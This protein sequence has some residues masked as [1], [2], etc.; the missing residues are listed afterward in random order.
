MQIMAV[1]YVLDLFMILFTMVRKVIRCYFHKCSSYFRFMMEKLRIKC[2]Q[3]YFLTTTLANNREIIIFFGISS[4]II[5]LEFL[6]FFKD[7]LMPL[8]LQT[9]LVNFRKF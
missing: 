3:I 9:E 7:S 4:I 8:L 1:S 5:L 6:L 2:S